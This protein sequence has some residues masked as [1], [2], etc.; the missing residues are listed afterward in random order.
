MG[1][2]DFAIRHS[3]ANNEAPIS[4]LTPYSN[5]ILTTCLCTLFLIKHYI[6][7]PYLPHVYSH[8]WEPAPEA[9]KRSLVTLYLAVLI[10]VAM[11]AIGLYP[12][13]AL[14]FGSSRLSDPVDIFGGRVT[15]GDCIAISMNILPS[16]YLFEIIHRSRLSIVTWMHHVG[17]IFAAQSTLTLVTHGAA[18]ARYQFL[19]ITVW[20]FFDVIM[21]I[22][23]IFA[24]IRL[25]V[26]RG[27]HDHLCFVFKITAAWVFILNNIQSMLVA[28]LLWVIWDDWV[29]VFKIVTPLAYVLFTTT[30]WQQAYLYVQLMRKE[31]NQKLRKIA[32]KEVEG[33]PLTP[34]EEK[35]KEK[36]SN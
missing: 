23:P 12:V 22:A 13:I 27:D 4:I 1:L 5:I 32:L 28:Y 7:E 29:L 18:G 20:G 17:S 36:K 16:F 30:Q 14:I 3:P 25:R 11:V 34:E 24:L 15:M 9:I 2:S 26:V 10:R 21:E 33:H 8:M 31:L 35:E 6:L 19:V